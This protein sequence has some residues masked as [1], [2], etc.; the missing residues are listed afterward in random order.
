MNDKLTVKT[1]NTLKSKK[2]RNLSKIKT[3]KKV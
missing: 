1:N 3:K 2:E